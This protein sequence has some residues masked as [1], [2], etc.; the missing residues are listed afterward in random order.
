MPLSTSFEITVAPSPRDLTKWSWSVREAGRRNGSEAVESG[1]GYGSADAAKQAAEECAD[2][3]AAA[4]ALS[5]T[6]HYTPKAMK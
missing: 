1:Y 2:A 5:S 3:I 6:H 4:V